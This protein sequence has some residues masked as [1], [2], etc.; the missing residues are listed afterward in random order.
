MYICIY[1][2]VEYWKIYVDIIWRDWHWKIIF[3]GVEYYFD[4]N[5]KEKLI[6][7]YFFLFFFF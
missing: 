5:E 1:Y 6:C 3:S 2:V 4:L 7:A